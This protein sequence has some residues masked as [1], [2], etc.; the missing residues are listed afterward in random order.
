M[1]RPWYKSFNWVMAGA[2]VLL[3]LF[4]VLCIHS[5]DL[6]D[7]DAS[8]EWRKQI[9]YIGIGIVVMSTFASIDYHRWH[10]WAVGMFAGN[11][12]LLGLG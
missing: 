11:L 4:G 7:V 8:G 9:V 3:S 2:A 12:L 10:R 6:H 1:E 5:A